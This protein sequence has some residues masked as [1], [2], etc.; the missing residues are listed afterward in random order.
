MDETRQ[1]GM[2]Q[3]TSTPA[4]VYFASTQAEWQ[5]TAVLAEP[6]FTE[7]QVQQ[8]ALT[9]NVDTPG[10]NGSSGNGIVKPKSTRGAVHPKNKLNELAGNEWAYFTKTVVQSSYPSELG[11]RLRKRHFANK[12]PVLMKEIIG[13]FTKRGQTVLDPFAGVGGTLLGASL[14]GRQA[15]GVELE[16]QWLDIYLEVCRAEKLEPQEIICG[17]SLEVLPRLVEEGRQFDAIITDPPYSPALEKTMCDDKYGR[18]NRKS[19]FESF[20]SS[21]QDFRNSATFEEFYDRMEQVG[22]WFFQLLKPGHYS[23]VMIRDSYQN[24]EYIPASFHVAERFRKV[25]FKFKGIRI[26]YQTGAPV[27]PYGYPYTYVPNIVHHNILV[28]RKEQ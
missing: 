16:Q 21:P 26:W 9:L 12:P 28:F 14:G 25:G 3:P 22:H 18:G 11:H 10:K 2:E 20:S 6:T 15:T 19:P 4:D 13:F 27:R 5:P 17:D 24:G 23:A 8:L 7:G 1:P